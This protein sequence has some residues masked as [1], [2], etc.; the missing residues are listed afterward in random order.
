MLRLPHLIAALDHLQR[1]SLRLQLPHPLPVSLGH[2]RGGNRHARREWLIRRVRNRGA[3]EGS[4]SGR[5]QRAHSLENSLL[6]LNGGPSRRRQGRFVGTQRQSAA[7]P[8][9]RGSVGSREAG[10]GLGRLGD[11]E[12]HWALEGPRRGWKAGESVD[13]RLG[14][15]R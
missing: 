4:P 5:R 6:G 3:R 9:G 10:A 1:G 14:R 8:N 13:A 15:L 11:G 2:Q 7:G 12:S